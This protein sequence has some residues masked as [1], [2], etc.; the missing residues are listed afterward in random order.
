MFIAIEG[1]DGAGKT[2]LAKGIGNLLLSEGYRVYM[3][4]EPTDGMENYAGDGIELFL[5][6]TINRY[7]HQREIDNHMKNGEI[8]ICDRYIRS[9]YAYQF[10]GVADFFGNS[11]RAWE[12]MNSVSEIIR[13]RPDM[14]IYVDVDE[15]TAME[16]I[17]RRGLKN[18]H[19]ENEQK[20]R[21]VRQ[22]YRRFQW[23]LIVDGGRDIDEIISETFEKIIARLRQEKA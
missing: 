9:S 2:T 12:W 17:S 3:T 15:K 4:K 8:V 10:E 11:E 7:A 14:Q 20:L 13:I 5:K 19:F 6:F 21:G 23:D 1:I 18:P 16:R 22:I